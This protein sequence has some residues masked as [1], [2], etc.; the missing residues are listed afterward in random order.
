MDPI[1]KSNTNFCHGWIEGRLTDGILGQ[2]CD[3]QV[4]FLA[5]FRRDKKWCLK[6][7]DVLKAV[8]N[9]VGMGYSI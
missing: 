9:D 1:D 8:L 5:K 2:K 4:L 7:S 3:T 6:S